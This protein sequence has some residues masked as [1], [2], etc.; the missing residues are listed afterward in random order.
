MQ[1]N[2]RN[3]EIAGAS[4]QI[5][6]HTNRNQ[7]KIKTGNIITPKIKEKN[8]PDIKNWFKNSGIAVGPCSGIEPERCKPLQGQNYLLTRLS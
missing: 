1:Y 5:R 7:I 6:F 2:I 4:Q 3:V 8:F